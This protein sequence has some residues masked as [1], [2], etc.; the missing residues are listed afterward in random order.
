[1]S[2]ITFDEFQK[3]PAKWAQLASS[4]ET[5]LVMNG[6]TPLAKVI[7]AVPPV[8]KTA[9]LPDREEEIRKLPVTDS[10]RFI[11]EFRADREL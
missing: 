8:R 9:R 1:M 4:G 7:P 5:V 3:E 10:D 2:T 11:Q 6:S